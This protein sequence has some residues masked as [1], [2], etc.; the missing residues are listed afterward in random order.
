ME[1]GH[2]KKSI[3]KEITNINTISF[4]IGLSTST[5]L[6]ISSSYLKNSLGTENVSLFY[7]I[8]YFIILFILLNLHK[9]IK[10]F[11]KSPTFYLFSV[12]KIIALSALAMLPVSAFSSSFLSFYIIGSV[13]TAVCMDVILESFSTNGKSGRIRGMFLMIVNTG[14]IFGPFISTQILA[15]YDFKTVFLVSLCLEIMIL[16]MAVISLDKA[17][18]ATREDIKIIDILKKI[19]KH[20]NIVRIYY[21]SLM[22]EFFY[23]LMIVYSPIYLRD[24][25]M[26][27][28]NIGFAFTLMLVPFVIL[29]YAIGY[30]ADKKIGEKEL[31]IMAIFFMSASTLAVYLT[32]S[33]D[34]WIWALVLLATRIGAAMIDTLRDSYFY[35][36]INGDDVD[37]IDF[38]RTAR[39]VGYI[40]GAGLSFMLLL[41]FPIKSIFI[42][43]SII[44]FS[45][46]YPALRL[47][48]NKS[49]E[50]I[51][52]EKMINI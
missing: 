12:L 43:L 29:P 50:E 38:F 31:I 44:S 34:V 15:N 22:L 23:Y 35:K 5:L 32:D 28:E 4:V 24:L 10:F 47:L 21:I 6:Y 51:S 26:S 37:L 17:N 18:H 27:W 3:N 11:G 49:E 42:L 2:N 45:A 36:K 14:F 20:K 52:A 25:G 39:P 40:A 13:V 33:A 1:G 30:L 19:S 16:T 8:S 9:L 46:F 48:D 7:L 41:F